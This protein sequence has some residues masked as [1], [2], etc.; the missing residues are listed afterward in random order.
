MSGIDFKSIETER[1]IL[2]QFKD[3]DIDS[4]YKYRANPDVALYQGWENYI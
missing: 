2:R 3:S 4:F 1:L